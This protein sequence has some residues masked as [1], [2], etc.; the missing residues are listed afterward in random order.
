MLFPINHFANKVYYCFC[1]ATYPPNTWQRQQELQR[2][3]KR[4]RKK[5]AH[6][7]CNTYK[8]VI[9]KLCKLKIKQEK[10]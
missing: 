1:S 7:N 6:I 8:I 10:L 9:G 5:M 4:N 2:T 3:E